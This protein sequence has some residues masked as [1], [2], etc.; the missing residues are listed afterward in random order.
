M[1][2]YFHYCPRDNFIIADYMRGYVYLQIICLFSLF[3]PRLSLSDL[4]VSWVVY[5]NWK[6]RT[7]NYRSVFTRNVLFISEYS[8]SGNDNS[9]KSRERKETIFI[10]LS[11]T[12][13]HLQTNLDIY[14]QLCIWDGCHIFLIAPLAIRILL[15]DEICCLIKLPFDWFMMERS[16]LLF[17]L[18]IFFWVD[19][20]AVW[21]R[22][23]FL[24]RN[25]SLGQKFFS[26]WELLHPLRN[27]SPPEK[28]FHREDIFFKFCVLSLKV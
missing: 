19:F 2:L 14:L 21:H 18:A 12:P 5:K 20:I 9:Q 8:L 22:E 4:P 10:L 3:F 28:L 1:L 17:Y 13:A 25:L 7:K 11:T 24:L 23:A 15:L 16:F 26:S 27:L 6:I